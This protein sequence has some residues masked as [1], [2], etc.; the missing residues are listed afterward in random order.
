[1]KEQDSPIKFCT[2]F[3]LYKPYN[4]THRQLTVPQD[5][6]RVNLK[7]PIADMR[8]VEHYCLAPVFLLD[9]S[10]EQCSGFT[11]SIGYRAQ[12]F[13]QFVAMFPKCISAFGDLD[14]HQWEQSH[15]NELISRRCLSRYEVKGLEITNLNQQ[16]PDCNMA[17]PYL[18][19]EVSCSKKELHKYCLGAVEYANPHRTSRHTWDYSLQEAWGKTF[20]QYLSWAL[21]HRPELLFLKRNS[22]IEHWTDPDAFGTFK[23]GFVLEYL[24]KTYLKRETKNAMRRIMTRREAWHNNYRVDQDVIDFFKSDHPALQDAVRRVQYACKVCNE[25]GYNF[26]TFR[27]GPQAYRPDSIYPQEFVD[28][29]CPKYASRWSYTDNRVSPTTAR[30]ELVDDLCFD[31]YEA[32]YGRRPRWM[33]VH[34][35]WREVCAGQRLLG[36]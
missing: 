32:I 25:A 1:M 8:D 7:D 27:W 10:E 30:S 21:K 28:K 31:L 34:T 22:T 35:A 12:L 15:I 36:L 4:E 18:M 2:Y 14:T 24:M 5:F 29:A 16:P 33:D 19:V 17:E 26:S 13:S 11:G 3:P 20:P 6:K 9:C 23:D